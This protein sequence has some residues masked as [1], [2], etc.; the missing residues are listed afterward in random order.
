[1]CTGQR[2]NCCMRR[3]SRVVRP[4]DSQCHSRNCPTFDPS[5]LRHSGIWGATDEAVLKIV[6][7][8]SKFVSGMPVPKR[9][10]PSCLYTGQQISTC[11]QKNPTSLSQSRSP[12]L[13]I[14]LFIIVCY[15]VDLKPK[16]VDYLFPFSQYK[17]FANYINISAIFYFYLKRKLFVFAPF[18][19]Y[20]VLNVTL[21]R[22]EF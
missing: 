16:K 13:F 3:S 18:H 19:L 8:K 9:L 10:M 21:T 6:H 2:P 7:K 22:T 20:T 17:N 4:S 15:F 1:M 11:F 5:I 12:P 14:Y